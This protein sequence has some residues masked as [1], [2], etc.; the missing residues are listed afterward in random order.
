[1]GFAG[2]VASPLDPNFGQDSLKWGRG[3]RSSESTGD[4]LTIHLLDDSQ[5]ISPQKII[6]YWTE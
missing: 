6:L 1:M 4:A 2:L 3:P 5:S